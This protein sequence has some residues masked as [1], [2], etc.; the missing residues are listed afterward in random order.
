MKPYQPGIFSDVGNSNFARRLWRFLKSPDILIR[1]DTAT[2][3]R[4]SACEAIQDELTKKFIEFQGASQNNRLFI[5]HKQMCGHMVRQVMEQRGHVIDSQ[6]I[7]LRVGNLFRTA[8][9]YK[10]R[11]PN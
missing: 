10:K 11:Q 4:R 1:M 9:R 2:Y 6:R 7:P 5:R 8:T 3:L